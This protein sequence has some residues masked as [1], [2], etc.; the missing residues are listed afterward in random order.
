MSAISHWAEHNNIKGK[1]I[2]LRPDQVFQDGNSGRRG[3]RIIFRGVFY[4]SWQ[5]AVKATGL[6]KATIRW[7]LKHK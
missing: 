2:E 7:R 4:N 1:K 6:T 5:E 3:T